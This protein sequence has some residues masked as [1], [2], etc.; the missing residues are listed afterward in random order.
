[1]LY[2]SYCLL[3]K[4]NVLYTLLKFSIVP[5]ST[6]DEHTALKY[7]SSITRPPLLSVHNYD[8][9]RSAADVLCAILASSAEMLQLHIRIWVPR[10]YLSVKSTICEQFPQCSRSSNI[11][12]V[13]TLPHW[14]PIIDT[15]YWTHLWKPL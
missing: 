11:Q 5:F 13:W 9:S 2:P 7:N 1:M 3:T 15:V 12:R 14:M 6:A 8:Q 4:R 10:R